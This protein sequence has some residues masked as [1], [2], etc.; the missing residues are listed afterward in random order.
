MRLEELI[1]RRL[2]RYQ[3]LDL[4][5]RGGMAAVYRA[6]DT[7]LLRDVALK[8][9]YPQYLGDQALVERFQREAVVAARLDHPNIVPIYDV[10]EAD[11]LTYI[12]MKLLGTRSLADVLRA[13]GTLTLEELAPIVSQ[14]AAALDYAHARG[15]VHRD[16]KP[17]NILLEGIGQ[18]SEVIGVELQGGVA[19][20]P[21]PLTHHL[22]PDTHAVLTDF[23]IARSLDAPGLTGTGVLIGT[24]DYMAPE[25][26]RGAPQIDGRAD[27]YALG[28]LIYRCLTGRRPFEGTTQEVL[29]GHLEG[30]P[31]PLS[32][33]DPALPAGVDQVVRRAMARRP[34]DRYATAGE[35]ARALRSA[36]GLE[37]LTPPP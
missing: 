2:G 18:R 12:A 28:V 15:V 33:L 1:G 8:V 31:A 11:G 9:L 34:E 27:I 26:I 20:P 17:A 24:P 35:L 23:G 10:G 19:S 13:R 6:R 4:I 25:Q 14:I 7:L 32:A 22:S 29:I 5:G 37:P 21:S 16:I 30:A 36:A 3:I